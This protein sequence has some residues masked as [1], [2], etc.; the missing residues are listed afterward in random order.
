MHLSQINSRG[1]LR[2][3]K[4]SGTPAAYIHKIAFQDT[5][6]KGN[7][8]DSLRAHLEI[9]E[10]DSEVLAAM[11]LAEAEYEDYKYYRREKVKREKALSGF[12][13]YGMKIV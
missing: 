3:Q 10:Y 2:K 13:Q 1:W 11:D 4:Q 8:A 7:S 5:S 6:W 9:Q 12:N